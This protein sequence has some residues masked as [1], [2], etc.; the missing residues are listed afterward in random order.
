M[1]NILWKADSSL[2]VVR[3]AVRNERVAADARTD[4][5]TIWMRNVESLCTFHFLSLHYLT[6]LPF[7]EVVEDA[8]QNFA[9]SSTHQ[10]APL[11]PLPLAPLTHSTSSN[12]ETN[13]SSRLPRRMLAASEIFTDDTAEYTANSTGAF[14][15]ANTT[16]VTD[17]VPSG[18]PSQI[19]PEIQIHTPSRQRRATVSGRSPEAPLNLDLSF[20]TGSPSKR[21]EKS[22]SHGN[23]FQRHIAPVSFLEAELNKRMHFMFL[24][25]DNQLTNVKKRIAEEPPSSPRL[26]EVLDSSLFIAPLASARSLDLDV[27]D[28]SIVQPE[29][30]FDDLTSS[31][32][33][34]EPYPVR[35]ST[36][37]IPDS[38]YQRRVEGVYDRFLMATS[39]VKRLG[40]GYQSDNVGPVGNAIGPATGAGDYNG[41]RD[42]HRAFYSAKRPMPPPVSSEDVQ[43][44]TMSV[45]E[46]GVVGAAPAAKGLASS[47]TGTKDEIS[48]G[49]IMKR[50]KA[51]VPVNPVSRRLSRLPI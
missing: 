40:K 25:C 43:K 26:S 50:I 5:M 7:A 38:P 16:T 10:L 35:K 39:G 4:R 22:K 24:P 42:S 48:T 2:P 32:F 20:E 36:S 31:P 51:M 14:A 27:R 33:H 46:L 11:P 18:G 6:D 47:M 19:L 1:L 15:T 13:R 8:Q 23:L 9:S 44:Q 29:T 12:R 49:S 41:K 30:P 28:I 3:H 37:Q 45:D 21:R 34:V 17:D